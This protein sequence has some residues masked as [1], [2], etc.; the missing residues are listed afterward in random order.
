MSDRPTRFVPEF[1]AED[2]E[3]RAFC[4]ALNRLV[5]TGHWAHGYELKRWYE[6][7]ETFATRVPARDHGLHLVIGREPGEDG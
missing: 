5:V 7:K 3:D 1:T 2:I 6:A 4:P